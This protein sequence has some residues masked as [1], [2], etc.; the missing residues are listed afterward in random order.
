MTGP[1][2]LVFAKRT[3]LANQSGSETFYNEPNTGF[4]GRGGTNT[5][6]VV[7]GY[8]N[9]TANATLMGGAANNV[10]SQFGVSNNAGNSTYNYAA[11]STGSRRKPWAPT[12]P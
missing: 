7:A 2:G 11:V 12:R 4:T 6:P 1:T 3:R 10:G 8:G 5:D 9:S